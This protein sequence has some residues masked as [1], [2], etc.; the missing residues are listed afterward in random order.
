MYA[1]VDGSLFK[2]FQLM[3]YLINT[4]VYLDPNGL[5]NAANLLAWPKWDNS[6]ESPKL[7]TFSDGVVAA[8]GVLGLSV[9]LDT[10]RSAPIK[11][12][13]FIGVK[14]E[15]PTISYIPCLTPVL[16]RETRVSDQI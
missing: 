13:Q 4:V 3:D 16:T 6:L 11:F 12:L 8:A 15:S 9:T 7:M 5:G 14:C 10:Y 1:P 2:D